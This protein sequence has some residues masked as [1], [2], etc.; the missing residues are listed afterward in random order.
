MS[1]V[2]AFFQRLMEVKVLILCIIFGGTK[3]FGVDPT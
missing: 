1:S 3:C 2:I